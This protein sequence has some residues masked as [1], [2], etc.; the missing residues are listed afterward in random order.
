MMTGTVVEIF[1]P[2]AGTKGLCRRDSLG[3]DYNEHP[4]SH[5]GRFGKC[6]CFYIVSV[7]DEMTGA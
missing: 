1:I 5:C 7:L 6:L 4:G 2:A 3:Y